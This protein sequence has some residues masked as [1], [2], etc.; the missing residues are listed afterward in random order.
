MA[1]SGYLLEAV[2]DVYSTQSH[3][4][5]IVSENSTEIPY[6]AFMMY[7]ISTSVQIATN[8]TI[9]QT[10][11][12]LE[13]GHGFSTSSSQVEY[14]QFF[15]SGNNAQRKVLSV[16]TNDITI[17]EPLNFA[18][19]T[20]A[21]GKRSIKNF[22][23]NASATS[24]TYCVDSLTFTNILVVKHITI[25]GIHSA[26]SDLSKFMGISELVNGVQF[27]KNLY[28]DLIPGGVD[29]ALGK[30]YKNSDFLLTGGGSVQ[31]SDK[32]GG[33]AYGTIINI[34]FNDRFGSVI[35]LDSSLQEKLCLTINDNLNTITSLEVTVYGK[36]QNY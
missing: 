19:T 5:R 32:G 1:E 9:G 29:V 14:M 36:F 22:G 30:V 23:I 20:A 12:S 3:T 16:S 31:F 13:A 34:N 15:E 35:T 25:V 11:I 10:I 7:D 26:E 4:F 17:N 33:G 18:F 21:I 24:A 6:S 28:G 8:T 27:K 2:K